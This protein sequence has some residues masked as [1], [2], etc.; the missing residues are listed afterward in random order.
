MVFPSL[1]PFF[2]FPF[3]T[4]VVTTTFSEGASDGLKLGAVVGND[5]GFAVGFLLGKDDGGE[6]GESVGM[7]DVD[8]AEEGYVEGALLRVGCDDGALLGD[9]DV[10]GI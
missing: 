4:T 6:L 1:I 5:E 9:V 2:P 7:D 8:G 3:N 10:V